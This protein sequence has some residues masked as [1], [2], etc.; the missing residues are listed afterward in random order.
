MPQ[1]S[2]DDLAKKA[3]ANADYAGTLSRA[4]VGLG[5]GSSKVRGDADRLAQIIVMQAYSSAQGIAAVTE[6]LSEALRLSTVDVDRSSVASADKNRATAEQVASAIMEVRKLAELTV[7]SRRAALLAMGAEAERRDSSQQSHQ[8]EDVGL[9]AC[10]SCGKNAGLVRVV[11]I[12]SAG[13]CEE[14]V[15]LCGQILGL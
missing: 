11:A 13:I 4:I 15:R 12:G 3:L 1:P 8:S 7:G 5:V 14:C 9:R 6:H 2:T 10:C